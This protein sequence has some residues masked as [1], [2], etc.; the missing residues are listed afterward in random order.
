MN[1]CASGSWDTDHPPPTARLPG[2]QFAVMTLV[3]K[4]FTVV[5]FVSV[6]RLGAAADAW[7][8]PNPSSEPA[9]TSPTSNRFTDTP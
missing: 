1:G 9:A 4:K 2:G 3:E 5:V 6:V 7:E 8:I